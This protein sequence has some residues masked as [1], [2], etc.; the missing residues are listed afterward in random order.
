MDKLTELAIPL[1]HL[2]E[3]EVEYDSIIHMACVLLNQ[4]RVFAAQTI[5]MV[6]V[7]G[8]SIKVAGVL[9]CNCVFTCG[10]AVTNNTCQS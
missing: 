10:V 3:V 1:T 2:V 5:T 9:G 7:F 4:M 6:V 8:S